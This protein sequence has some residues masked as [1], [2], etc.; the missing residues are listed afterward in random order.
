M[1]PIVAFPLSTEDGDEKDSGQVLGRFG[2]HVLRLKGVSM[3]LLYKPHVRAPA[4]GY[5][6]SG[7]DPY[8]L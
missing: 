1:V 3:A 2:D 5:G 8:L 6:R 7:D 4:G